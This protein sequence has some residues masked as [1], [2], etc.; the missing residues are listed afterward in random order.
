MTENKTE[1]SLNRQLD[2][3]NIKR[4]SIAG[5]LAI[6]SRTFLLQILAFV[7]TFLLTIFLEPQEYGI[8]FIVS[9][10]V[11]FLV[12]FSDVGLAAALIQ[13]KDK[14]QQKDYATTFTIQQ[15]LVI[16]LSAISLWAS[17]FIARFYNLS[18]DGLWL[19]RSLV[20]AFFLS[21]LKTIPSV[22]LERRLKFNLLII[23]QIVENVFFYSIAVYMAWKGFGVT[24]FSVAVLARGISGLITIYIL[25]PWWPKISF[26]KKAA[27]K[28]LNFG[29]PF[30]L[31]SILALIKDD[32][33]TAFLGKILPLAQVGFLGWAQRWS[34]FPLRMFMD[35]INKVTFPAY[36]RLQKHKRSLTKAIDKSLFFVSLTIF[37]ALI[38]LIA[39]APALVRLIPRYQKWEPALLALSLFT[40]NSLWASIST[41]LT[42]TLAALGKIKTNLK[43]MAMWTSLTW[44]ITPI[45][46]FKIG[47]NGAALAAAIVAFTSFIPMILVKRIVSI[48]ISGNVLPSFSLASIMG[49]VAY[50]LSTKATTLN[51]AIGVILVSA[52]LYVV[53]TLIVQG[54]RLKNEMNTIRK[55][56][57]RR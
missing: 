33:L 31:N 56:L 37:P 6:T 21:S 48:N 39:T 46:V 16:S 11:N 4:R 43:L 1:T 57:I 55:I 15:I 17:T 27:K 44:I 35:S 20:I 19:Y 50:A 7:A 49:V 30:Q 32:F 25:A 51:Q 23:P 47:Y 34:L 29:I 3:E 45:L 36:S 24:S 8:F 41:T 52:I 38:G 18:A 13:K 53:L 26:S 42:N 54:R 14:L 2:L 40:I 22:K 5:I 12:Y 10:V 28:L 9:A